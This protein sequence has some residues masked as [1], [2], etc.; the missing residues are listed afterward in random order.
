[1]AVKLHRCSLTWVKGPHPCW[2]VQKALDESG[3]DYEVVTHSPLRGRRKDWVA[4][5]G[6]GKL[7]GIEFED[8]QVLREESRDLAKRIR[9][10]GLSEHRAADTPTIG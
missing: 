4:K 3:V 10:G 9:S 2:H 5:S 8:G 6:Q 1:M 7:P